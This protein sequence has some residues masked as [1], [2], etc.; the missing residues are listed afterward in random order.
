[1]A[2]SVNSAN[3]SN[4]SDV[5]FATSAWDQPEVLIASNVLGG[6]QYS[7]STDA[8]RASSVPTVTFEANGQAPGEVLKGAVTRFSQGSSR[9][10]AQLFSLMGGSQREMIITPAEPPSSPPTQRTTTVKLAAT[11]AIPTAQSAPVEVTP[12]P[13][14]QED[15]PIPETTLAKPSST[16]L[17]PPE[18]RDFKATGDMEWRPTN[19][20]GLAEMVFRPEHKGKIATVQLLSE[21]GTRVIG[22]PTDAG[23]DSK[24]RP[25]WR[26]K[27]TGEQYPKGAILMMTMKD[28][29]VRY[30][31]IPNPA[32]TF[33]Y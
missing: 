32:K 19:R 11:S 10:L 33:R 3:N 24:G 14:A 17:V 5:L 31:E 12:E 15:L 4:Q 1:M 18:A 27:K 30:M 2:S 9:V 26:F 13:V 21:D 23:S 22:T 28:G 8:S 29:G 7:F 16:Y 20:Y 6:T 25:V